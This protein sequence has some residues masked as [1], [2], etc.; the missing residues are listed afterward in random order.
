MEDDIL[1]SDEKVKDLKDDKELGDAL[2]STT[3]VVI[4][5]YSASCGHC[6]TMWPIIKKLANTSSKAKFMRIEKSNI[7]EHEPAELSGYPHYVVV[8]DGPKKS[9]G[10]EMDEK[11]LLEKL[12]RT[13]G[14]RSRRP[15]HRVRKSSHRSAGRRVTFRSKLRSTRKRRG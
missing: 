15:V 9:F 14:G 10:G 4:F 8:G 1:K 11:S 13:G 2:E 7:G 5:M 3:P 12:F 6:K